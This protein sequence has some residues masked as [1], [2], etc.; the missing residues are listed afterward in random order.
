MRVGLLCGKE[1]L[2][3]DLEVALLGSGQACREVPSGVVLGVSLRDGRQQQSECDDPQAPTARHGGL[4][5]NR[6]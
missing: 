1:P 5:Y 3:R 6:A 4:R 2:E